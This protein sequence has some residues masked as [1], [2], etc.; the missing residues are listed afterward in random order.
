MIASPHDNVHSFGSA[1]VQCEVNYL[2]LHRDTPTDL[3]SCIAL[4]MLCAYPRDR[5]TSVLCCQ[6]PMTRV[7]DLGMRFLYARSSRH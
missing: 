2:S 3:E 1:A 6:C 4:L 7:W 5:S